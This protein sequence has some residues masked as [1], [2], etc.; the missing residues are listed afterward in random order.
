MIA[1]LAKAVGLPTL[2]M[3]VRED[4]DSPDPTVRN[5]TAKAVAVIANALGVSKLLP[6][7]KA[8]CQT[9]K[10]WLAK[11]TG[12]KIIQ[13]LAI[14]LG[15]SILPHLKTLVELAEPALSD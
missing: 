10:S 12:Y 3:A 13:Q 14:L 7:I 2:I 9:K 4:I 5:V 8:L 6:F 1:N 15:C 11:H